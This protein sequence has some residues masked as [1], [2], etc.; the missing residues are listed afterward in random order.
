M[1]DIGF[2]ELTVIGVVLLIVMGPER[3]PEVARQA[4]FLIRKTRGWVYKMKSE[5][6]LEGDETLQQF[7]DAGRELRDFQNDMRQMGKD[8]IKNNIDDEGL[9]DIA[10]QPVYDT[11]VAQTPE[12]ATATTPKRKKTA[13]KRV[14][15]KNKATTTQ[16]K[17]TS[18]STAAETTTKSVAKKPAAKKVSK[19]KAKK[20]VARKTS[21]NRKKTTTKK[22][23]SK[24]D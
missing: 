5:M 13:K 1:F 7:K 11:D 3:L 2:F 18:G 8:V 24:A 15:K 17:P 21:T 12:P 4:A 23:D 22:N 20:K 16:S 14:S 6:N 9:S 19:K 10:D